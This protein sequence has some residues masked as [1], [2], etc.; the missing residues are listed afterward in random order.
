VA[1]RHRLSAALP[2]AVRSKFAQRPDAVKELTHARGD[3][4]FAAGP[5][6]RR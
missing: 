2:L 6:T 5:L 4:L 1:L 3:A